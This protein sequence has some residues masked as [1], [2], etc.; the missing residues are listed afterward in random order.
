MAAVP[1]ICDFGW[2]AVDFELEG[3]DGKRYGLEE[4]RGSKGTLV[5]FIC[6]HCPYVRSVI[7]RIVRDVKAL[8]AEGILGGWLWLAAGAALLA[9]RP[10][11]TRRAFLELA[12]F[13]VLVPVVP[14]IVPVPVMLLGVFVCFVQTLVFCLLSIIYIALAI[15]HAEEH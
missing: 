9:L 6:N 8:Q 11:G 5:M 10:F 15:E 2:K 12:I 13:T 14:L 4:V 7:D 1:P 3:I